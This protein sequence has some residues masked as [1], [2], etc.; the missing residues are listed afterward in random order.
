[1]I[2]QANV[3]IGRRELPGLLSTPQDPAGLVIFAHGSGSSRLSPRNTYAAGELQRRGFSTLLY[4][5][6]TLEESS[7][8]SNVF[9]MALLAARVEEA[10][11]WAR[12]GQRTSSL[13]IGLFGASTGAGAAIVAA[14]AQPSDVAAVVSRGGRPD[15]A[16]NALEWL[17]APTLLIVGGEDR[18]VI[19]LNEAAQQRMSCET[20]LVI[21]PGAGHLFEEPGTLDQALAAAADWFEIHLREARRRQKAETIARPH[22]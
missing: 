15:L 20:A 14:A 11:D 7:D 17:T 1:M 18:D 3:A 10:I 4:D 19:T 12:N 16:G 22:H 8:R 2:K 6:L 13:R 5:L 21:V 9:N